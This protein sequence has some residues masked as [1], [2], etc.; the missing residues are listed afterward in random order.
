[1]HKPKLYTL[2]IDYQGGTYICQSTAE[3]RYSAPSE[4]IK[5]WD[6]KD[7]AKEINEKDKETILLE[8]QEEEFVP[9]TGVYNVWCG[10]VI[11]N[12]EYMQ[13][14][15]VETSYLEE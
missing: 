6:I 9:I 15:L 1:M 12:N 2:I 14:N 8:L 7:L 13:I 11:L 5:K 4:C 10:G 3:D